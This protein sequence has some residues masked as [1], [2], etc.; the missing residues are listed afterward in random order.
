MKRKA[1]RKKLIKAVLEDPSKRDQISPVLGKLGVDMSSIGQSARPKEATNKIAVKPETTDFV[2]WA[3]ST[4]APMAPHEVSTFVVRTLGIKTSP[5]LRRRRGHRYL[6]GDSVIIKA[7]K[8]RNNRYDRGNYDLYDGKIGTVTETQGQDALVSFNGKPPVRFPGA[9][10]PRGVGI[11]KYSKPYTIKGS[12]KIEMIYKAGEKSTPD[13]KVVVDA[14]IG[15][16]RPLE[17]RSANYYTGY[18]VMAAIGKKGWYFRGFPQQRM[19]VDPN[20]D[21]GYAARSFNPSLGEIFYIGIFGKRP[22]RWKAELE[23]IDEI[24]AGALDFDLPASDMTRDGD[25]LDTAKQER[26]RDT[27]IAVY[28]DTYKDLYKALPDT[29]WEGVATDDIWAAFNGLRKIRRDRDRAD[30]DLLQGPETLEQ[31]LWG[32]KAVALLLEKAR[33]KLDQE[34]SKDPRSDEEFFND[35]DFD[36]SLM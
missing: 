25:P 32:E 24:S 20:S 30:Y 5:G 28:S 23:S 21:A 35:L 4:Q 10:A 17:R 36:R 6:P 7:N 27:A 31:T 22:A 12:A 11:Y 8:H 13:A 34:Q 15:R 33:A 19:V 9:L 26:D 16:G 29:T 14:Y 18:V 1:L 3:L 2:R